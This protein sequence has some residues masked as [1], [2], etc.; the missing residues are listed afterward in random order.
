MIS[1]T[2]VGRK[3]EL[4]QI[5]EWLEKSAGGLVWITGLG[6]IGKTALLRRVADQYS[7]DERFVVDYFDLAEQPMTIINQAVHLADSLGRGNFPTFM[8]K[9]T[10]LDTTPGQSVTGHLEEEAIDAC[11][12]EVAIY[13]KSKK[14]KLLRITDTFEIALKYTLYEDNWV[15]GI[16]ERLG[17]LAGTFFITAGRDKLDNKDILEVVHPLLRKLFKEEILHLPLAGFDNTEMED[18]FAECDPHL[19]IPQEMREKLQVLTDGRPILLS[20]A[21]DWL[22]K[23]I[24]LPV[25]I[26]KS[27]HELRE[28][29]Q[30]DSERINLQSQFE[31]ELVSKMRELQSPLDIASLYMAHL[32]RRM[33]S[34]LLSVLLDVD[35]DKA[36]EYLQELLNLPFVKEY[37]GSDPPKCTLHDEMRELVKRHA[38]QYLDISGEER[39]RLTH[40][41]IDQYYVPR[42]EFLKQKKLNLLSKSRATL[43]QSAQARAEDQERWLLEAET[44]YYNCKLGDLFGF[45]FFDQAFYDKEDS[46]IR[47]QFLLDELKRAGLDKE[48]I[49]LRDADGL[50]RRGRIEEA[51][52]ICL[53]LI[54]KGDLDIDERIHAYTAL[55]TMA[56][57]N[58]IGAEENFLKALELA[59][60]NDDYRVQIILYNNL[61]RL[62]RSMSKLDDSIKHFNEALTISRNSRNLDSGVTI[63]NNLAWTYRLNGNLDSADVLCRLA[64]TEN[65]KL[66]QERPLAYAYLTKADIDR[67]KG[68]LRNAGK[69]VRQA[70]EIFGRLD[71]VDGKAQAYRT[72]ANIFR[73][74]HNFD[75][76]LGCLRDGI[77]L[78]EENNSLPVLASLYQLYGRTFRHYATYIRDEKNAG[79][80]D[81]TKEETEFFSNALKALRTSIDVSRTIGNRW[82]IARS[83][84]EIVMIMMLNQAS[85]AER[86]LNDLLDQ[87]WQTASELDD[88]L[89]KGYVFEN[90]ARLALRTEDYTGAGQAIGEASFYIS[91]RTGVEISRAFARFHNFLLNPELSSE[92]SFA[93][94][95]GT[96]ERLQIQEYQY[97][98]DH[99][100][101]AALINLCD[102]ILELNNIGSET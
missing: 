21:V 22:Q 39:D 88:N 44:V 68:D 40:K 96:K 50:R 17:E 10:E 14:K 24:P 4:K 81:R 56:E 2:F 47:D 90:R 92:Q 54:E 97:R 48:K 1:K 29:V 30:I 69:Y 33:D 46:Y 41:V 84:L 52:Q 98:L 8:Q 67:D 87:V 9:L 27:L 64:I 26:D 6:G 43:L 77:R 83:Q 89:L 63:R 59:L 70:L 60:S 74:L 12:Q 3:E 19:M 58:P 73:Y 100:K 78:A 61:G 45:Q 91:K 16:N 18:F 65:R 25:M 15:G 99:P 34:Q 31:F 42:I 72:Q 101:L 94:A 93:L 85:F 57:N 32:D 7:S 51:K 86:E 38:W 28:I 53:K 5:R 75:Q 23:E 102:Q 66:G 80:P 11:V 82:E 20:L 62:A 76:A 37:I 35:D 49:A 55:G 13:L 95:K 79:G 36:G 71:D